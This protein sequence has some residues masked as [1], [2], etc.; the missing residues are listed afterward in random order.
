MVSPRILAIACALA[1]SAC[2]ADLSD[3]RYGCA[4][5]LCPPDYTCRYDQLCY[6]PSSPTQAD[7]TTCVADVDCAS[8]RCLVSYGLAG[9]PGRCSRTCTTNTECGANS[10]CLPD[11]TCAKSC[12]T[13][14]ECDEAAGFGCLVAPGPTFAAACQRVTDPRFTSEQACDGTRSPCTM[15]AFCVSRTDLAPI[16]ICTWPCSLSTSCPSGGTCIVV[17][18]TTPGT[19]TPTCVHPCATEADCTGLSCISRK[20]GDKYCG[21]LQWNGLF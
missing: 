18:G 13:D 9:D 4:D 14:A 21:P 17:P 5:G 1:L 10:V 2:T 12:S 8:G 19:M 7:Y 3:G 16:G 6:G 20:N 11:G 15:P